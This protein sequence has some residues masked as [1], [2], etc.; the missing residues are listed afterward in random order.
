MIS[1]VMLNSASYALEE[2]WQWLGL[3]G[4]MMACLAWYALGREHERNN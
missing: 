1:G 4:L 3:I 2:K